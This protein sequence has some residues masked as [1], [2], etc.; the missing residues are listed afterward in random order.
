MHRWIILLLTL[1]TASFAGTVGTFTFTGTA[2]GTIG[3]TAFSNAAL[4]VSAPGDFSTVS[5]VGGLC[6]LNV[7][8]GI[9]SF[10]IGGTGSGTF[11]NPTSFFDSQTGTLEGLPAGLVGFTDGSDDIQMYGALIG[12]PIFSTYT[13]QSAIGPLG[14]QPFNPS[15]GDWVNLSTSSGLFTVTSFTNFTFQVTA[16]TTTPEPSSLALLGIALG[17]LA[18]WKSKSRIFF[19]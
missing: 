12:N 2:S 17:G 19:D 10:V 9:T 4:T 1:D 15:T 16:A 14:P 6:K 13:L 5:C 11:S 7:A 3:G 18:V 8:A